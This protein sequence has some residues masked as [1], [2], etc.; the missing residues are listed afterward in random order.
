[1]SAA[2]RSCRPAAWGDSTKTKLSTRVVR[3]FPKREA[4]LRL[5]TALC[6]EQSEAWRAG[7]RYLDMSHLEPSEDAASGA[8]PAN[9]DQEDDMAA[10]PSTEERRS[11]STEMG[12]L[13]ATVRSNLCT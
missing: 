7:K 11:I 12:G 6:V 8:I 9:E 10:E 1:M 4:C 13:D 5:A 2:R 3:I